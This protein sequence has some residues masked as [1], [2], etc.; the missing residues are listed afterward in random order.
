MTGRPSSFTQEIA[1]TICERL[2]GGE[3]L[4]AICADAD[5]PNPSTVYRWLLVNEGFRE[6]YTHARELQADTLF[7]ECL[8]IANTPVIGKKSK[9]S[10]G[11]VEITE[12]DMIE[13]R[14]LQVDTRKWMAG[15]LRPKVYG[16]KVQHTGEG[17]GPITVSWQTQQES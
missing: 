1:D 4:V 11:K 16:D 12:G 7:D 14:R 3:S 9:L 2:A 13:H 15:K 6:S 10:D 5:M 17:G 8:L